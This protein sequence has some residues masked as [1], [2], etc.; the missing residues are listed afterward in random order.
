MMD[1]QTKTVKKEKERL[2]RLF[3]EEKR[4]GKEDFVLIQ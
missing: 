1:I 4:K 3:S 2:Q